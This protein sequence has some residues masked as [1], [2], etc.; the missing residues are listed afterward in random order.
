[1]M[2]RA[3]YDP[4][5][6]LGVYKRLEDVPDR[7]RLSVFGSAYEGRDV[8][9][10]YL[11]DDVLPRLTSDRHEKDVRRYGRRWKQ[12]LAE[13]CDGRHHALAD[14]EHIE[15]WS[16]ALLERFSLRQAYAHWIAIERFYTW[17]LTHTGHQHHVYQPF[18]MAAAHEGSAA[19]ELFEQKKRRTGTAKKKTTTKTDAKTGGEK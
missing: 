12:H 11:D 14:P 10:E 5:D 19:W 18:W 13:H 17:L 4:V 9:V 3:L 15:A 6:R 7:Y 16:A 8:W 2:A 1:M